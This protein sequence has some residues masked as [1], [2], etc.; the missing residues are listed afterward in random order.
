MKYDGID[1]GC[2]WSG[3]NVQ[4]GLFCPKTH[5]YPFFLNI[6]FL[7]VIPYNKYNSFKI[8]NFNLPSWEAYKTIYVDLGDIKSKRLETCIILKL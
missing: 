5:A 2:T 1:F 3:S 4:A 7:P 8:F 6:D